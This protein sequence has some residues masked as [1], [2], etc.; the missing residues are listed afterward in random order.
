MKK[1]LN[2][3]LL[4]VILAAVSYG[5]EIKFPAYSGYVNDLAG[6]IDA[7]SAGKLNMIAN[8]L[9]ETTGAEMA[10]ATVRTTYPLDTKSYATQ[11][12]EKWGIG[13]KEKDNGLL[14]LFVKKERR[15]EVEV[16]Y[17]LEGVITDG[18]AGQVLDK[19][20]MP[21]FRKNDFGKGIYMAA[22][23]FY[24]RITE[25]YSNQPPTKVEQINL[26]LF[27]VFLAVSVI[28]VVFLLALLGRT[29]IGAIISGIFGA[30]I[31]YFLAGIAGIFMGFLIGMM[32]SSGGY[33]GGFGG[34]GGGFGGFGGGE[35]GGF[36]GFGGGR[37][38]G[39]G[40]G[41]SF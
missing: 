34:M 1:I 32:I 13:K 5:A 3:L 4:I 24:D 26:N 23:A 22:L 6:V 21:E 18:F 38:G 8:K 20:A 40:A 15:V 41:R 28:I 27:S 33:Y 17:G 39:G 37:S 12:F 25:E 2:S 11:L 10:V 36:G 35:G 9:K 19:F 16:G 14:I 31:G 29:V 7:D 30:I